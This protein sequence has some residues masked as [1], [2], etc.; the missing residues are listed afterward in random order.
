M[1]H[2]Y[3]PIAVVKLT[4]VMAAFATVTVRTRTAVRLILIPTL[5]IAAAVARLVLAAMPPHNVTVGRAV[6]QAVTQATTTVTASIQMA[7]KST[8]TT[9]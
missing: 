3:V 4:P 6:S 2:Q 7:V 1:V 9:T 5:E 8:P